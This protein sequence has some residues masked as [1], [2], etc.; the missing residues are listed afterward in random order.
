MERNTKGGFMDTYELESTQ[1]EIC[2]EDVAAAIR[3]LKLSKASSH[4]LIS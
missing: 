2:D 4:G 1:K 3:D